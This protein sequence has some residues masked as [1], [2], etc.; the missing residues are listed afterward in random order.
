MKS[1]MLKQPLQTGYSKYQV[2][3]ISNKKID[4]M[5]LRKKYADSYKDFTRVR[6]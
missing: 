5:A 6:R 1:Y 2:I 3:R 4:T